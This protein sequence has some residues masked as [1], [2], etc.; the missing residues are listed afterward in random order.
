MSTQ[1]RAPSAAPA[2][3]VS[4]AEPGI[5]KPPAERDEPL[6]LPPD[7]VLDLGSLRSAVTSF[8]SGKPDARTARTRVAQILAEA[9]TAANAILQQAFAADPRNALPLIRSQSRMRNAAL[10]RKDICRRWKI[11]RII[12]L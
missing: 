8:C 6:L 9:R 1:P 4:P 11:F 3:E 5:L 10:M 2:T 7:T 12:S